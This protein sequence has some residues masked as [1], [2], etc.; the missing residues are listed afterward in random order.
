MATQTKIESNRRN[1]QKSTGPRTTEGKAVVAHNA[2]KHGL[3]ARSILL[4]HEKKNEW[5]VLSEDLFAEFQPVGALENLLVEGL[6]SLAW[7]RRRLVQVESEIF[8][9]GG[10]ESEL[11]N[12]SPT[13][14]NGL[15][16]AFIGAAKDSDAFSRLG[17]YESA[18]DRAF[19]HTLYELRQVQ[20]LRQ[21][22]CSISLLSP[23]NGIPEAQT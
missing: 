16:M 6:I 22:R 2:L 8:Q 23:E 21:R 1:A 3:C 15:G 11:F 7:R 9:Q 18:L 10:G 4:P 13:V 20:T 19:Y 17:R 14:G 12:L 5:Q